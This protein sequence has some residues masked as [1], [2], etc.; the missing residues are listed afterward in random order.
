VSKRIY[1]QAGPML[2]ELVVWPT[3][4]SLEDLKLDFHG[5]T[6]ASKIKVL[7]I[8]Q[9][10]TTTLSSGMAD[11]I[12]LG[13]S[14]SS[15]H[16]VGQGVFRLDLLNELPREPFELCFAGYTTDSVLSQTS[17][18]SSTPPKGTFTSIAKALVFCRSSSSRT[19][20]PNL[21]TWASCHPAERRSSEQS[22]L[23]T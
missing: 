14:I 20:V 23:P 3:E 21:S 5:F 16:F 9:G 8:Y 1:H 13:R 4:V 6:R 18:A 17:L 15:F 22:G 11:V 12:F 19:L 2:L 10:D 7:A